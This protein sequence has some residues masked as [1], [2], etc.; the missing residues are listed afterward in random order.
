MFGLM[1][2]YAR[3]A[4]P[5]LPAFILSFTS[6]GQ[7]HSRAGIVALILLLAADSIERFQ[8]ARRLSFSAAEPHGGVK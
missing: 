1:P 3:F 7:S 4:F 6:P 8:L 2:P 5:S